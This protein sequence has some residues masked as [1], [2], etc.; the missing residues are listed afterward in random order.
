MAAGDPA[1]AERK[2]NKTTA[3]KTVESVTAKRAENG[4]FIVR[5]SHPP[6][7]GGKGDGPHWEPDKEY[8]FSSYEEMAAFMGKAFGAGKK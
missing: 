5:C 7:I 4:G 6:A 8:A 1:Y 2:G 3:S